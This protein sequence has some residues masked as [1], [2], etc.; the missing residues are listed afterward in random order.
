MRNVTL[1]IEEDVL[2]KARI[3]AAKDGT[4]VNEVIR[5]YLAEYGSREDRVREAMDRF[6]EAAGRYHGRIKGGR[7]RRED[8]YVRNPKRGW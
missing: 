2:R 8:V 6:L 7:F 4:T 3:Q 1:A 5:R